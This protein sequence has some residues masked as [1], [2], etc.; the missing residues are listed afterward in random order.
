MDEEYN[1]RI[2]PYLDI[3]DKLRAYLKNSD[4]KV[5]V[6][7]TCGMQSSG[8]SSTLESI[9]HIQLPKGQNTVTLCPI[10]MQLRNTKEKEFARIKYESESEDLFKNIELNEIADEIMDYQNRLLQ[11]EGLAEDKKKLFDKPIQVEINRNKAP[12]LTL[13]D[14]PGLTFSENIEK[15]SKEICMKYITK[16]ETT[17][18]LVL[19]GQDDVSNSYGIKL[20]RSIKDSKNRFVPIISKSD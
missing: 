1:N 8:K 15:A 11:A 17:V 18:L 4:I 9:T 14:L 3:M 10:I 19:S 16:P 13:I 7:V 5:P 2:R 12:N 6:I 20:M